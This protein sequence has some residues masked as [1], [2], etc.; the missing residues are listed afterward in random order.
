[1]QLT[2]IKFVIRWIK[3]VD[4]IK[5]NEFHDENDIKMK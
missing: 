1:M 5:T 3:P 4:T 2:Q